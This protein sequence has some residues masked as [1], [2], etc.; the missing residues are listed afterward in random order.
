MLMIKQNLFPS[1]CLKCLN[2]FYPSG[3]LRAQT[4]QFSNTRT[5]RENYSKLT[6]E[7]PERRH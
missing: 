5:R 7:T 1:T 2:I 4:Q 3:H 6:I